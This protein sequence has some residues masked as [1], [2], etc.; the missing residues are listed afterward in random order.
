MAD[1]KKCSGTNSQGGPCGN[2]AIKGGTV[3]GSHGGRAPQ[4]KAK[5]AIRYELSSW[6]LGDS[7][8]D[9]GDVLLRLVT[10]SAARAERYAQ[11][12]EVMVAESPTLR[13]AL[14]AEVWVATERG[15]TYK[16]GEYLRGLAKLEAQE[17]DRCAT[18]AT[19]AV[20]A[21]LAERQVRLAEKQGEL[22]A[23]AIRAILDELGLTAE[24][25]A[26]A[27]AVV[28]RHLTAVAT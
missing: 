3:C 19:K 1:G 22:M 8:V 12:L 11:E 5:A 6:G 4:V 13:G 25:R 9:P 7:T 15:D 24:Q 10:Q 26:L 21:G 16:A 20:A 27:P 18:F 2:W 23:Q 14:I 28:R 17:R